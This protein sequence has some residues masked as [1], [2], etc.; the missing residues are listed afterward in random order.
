MLSAKRGVTP[1]DDL[2]EGNNPC[3]GG[4]SFPRVL[5]L[6]LEGGKD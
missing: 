5:V 4:Q 2:E 1:R 6:V 3:G